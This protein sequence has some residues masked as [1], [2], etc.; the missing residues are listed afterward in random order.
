MKCGPQWKYVTHT[1]QK[2]AAPIITSIYLV[3]FVFKIS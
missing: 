2:E 3:I 1:V